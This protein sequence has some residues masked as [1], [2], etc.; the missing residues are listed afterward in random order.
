VTKFAKNHSITFGA[1]AE[2]FHSDNSFYFGIQSSY[3]YNTL[4]DFYTD[5]NGYLAN[6]TRTVSP[7]T[8][9]NFYVKYLLQPGQTTPPLQML[10]VIYAGGYVQDEWRPRP[11]FSVTAGVRVDVPRF[12]NTAFDNPVADTLT[13]RDQ[14]GAPIQ[15]NTGKL[16]DTTPYWSPRVGFNW[17]ATGDQKTQVRGGTGL[18]S[19]KPPYVWI[20][21][22]IGNTGVLYGSISTNNTTAYP[23]NPNPDAYKPAP[24]GGT[25]ASYELDVTDK[26]FRFPQTW[27]SN[28]GVD[29][30]LPWGLTG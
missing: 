25:A 4:N 13:F 22:Q 11:N 16:P 7:V 24:T 8:L 30:R 1:N 5:A 14:N 18:F 23:F 29:R 19:G 2:K 10:D 9:L 12:G 20:S 27:R 17:D 6:R 3:S 21:N 26:S 28:V 15:Y